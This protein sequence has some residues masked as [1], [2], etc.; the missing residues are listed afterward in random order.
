MRA[1]PPE[2]VHAQREFASF[3]EKEGIYHELY[4]ARLFKYFYHSYPFLTRLFGYVEMRE[5]VII[6]YLLL[7]PPSHWC[8]HALDH[9]FVEWL[10]TQY[11]GFV[12]QAARL[13]AVFLR[14]Y[15]TSHLPFPNP[16][17][18]FFLQPTM[19]LW[20]SDC[21]LL[22][23]REQFLEK[24]VEHWEAHSFPKMT[25]RGTHYFIIFRSPGKEVEWQKI[26]KEQY[27]LLHVIKEGKRL[28]EIVEQVENENMGREDFPVWLYDW[29]RLGLLAS[30]PSSLG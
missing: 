17:S 1:P 8:L 19:E 18:L 6:P 15:V 5:K 21:D 11:E 16:S 30:A 27:Q 3:R 9:A 2:L 10:A 23:L 28:E 29:A 14:L 13:D 20:E 12:L 4:W 26:E 25:G 7:Y 24:S 22:S